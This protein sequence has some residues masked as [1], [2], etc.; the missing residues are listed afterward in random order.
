MLK[1]DFV[2]V[3]SLSGR[4]DVEVDVEQSTEIP[5]A[6][7]TKVVANLNNS[8]RD[9]T[10]DSEMHSLCSVIDC[11]KFSSLKKLIVTTGYVLRFIKNLRKRITKQENL[12]TDDM[13]TVAEFNEA[14]QLW[15]KDEQHLMK[16]QENYANI[17]SSLRL[18]E[19]EDGL[20]RLRGRFANSSLQYQE[21]Y[22]IILR[23]KDSHFTRLIISDAHE[24]SMHHG[25]ETTLAR[26]RSKYWIV[27]GRKS[28]KGP[29]GQVRGAQ[30]AVLS[31]LGKRT[32]VFR[33]LQKL[34]PFEIEENYADSES[35]AEG[36]ADKSQLDEFAR[37][38]ECNEDESTSKEHTDVNEDKSGTRCKRKAAIEGEKLRRLR[39]QYM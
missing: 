13:L 37:E 28:V 7:A 30:L 9:N 4:V 22:P 3:N 25:V 15:I 33:P 39:E 5:D 1:L 35:G 14:L 10:K 23:N 31:N 34:I 27:K 16:K 29:D 17:R 18:F 26:I 38:H 6:M 11:N 19:S 32:T 24:T 8:G 21:Q 20:L 36:T 12:I 2:D